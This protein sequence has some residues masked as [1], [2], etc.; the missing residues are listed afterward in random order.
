[1]RDRAVIRKF[2]VV[3]TLGTLLATPSLA[4]AAEE[5]GVFTLGEIEV[6]AKAEAEKNT[7]VEKLYSDEIRLFEKV[8]VADAANLLPGVT[9][10]FTGARNEQT[11]YVRGLDI[12]HVPLFIDGIPVY[13]PYDGYPDLARFTT[14]DLSTLVVSKGF[15]S[16]LYGPNTMGGAINMVSRRPEKTF[17][18]DLGAGIAS[19]ETYS[20][21]INLGTNQGKWYLQGGA[22]YLDSDYFPLSD[23]FTASKNENGGHRDNSYKTDYKFNLKAGFTPNAIDEYAISFIDQNGEK[24]TPVYTGSDRSVTARYWRWPYWDKQSYYFTSKTGIGQSSYVKT[25]AYHDTFKN[26]L[27]S[28]D[29]ATYTKISKKYAFRSWYDD[30]TDGGSLELGSSLLADHTIKLAMHYKRD[31]HR[32]QNEGAPELT[33][34]DQMFSIGL[35]DTWAFMPKFYTIAGIGYDSLDTIE[36]ENLNAKGLIEDFPTEATSGLTPQFGLFFTPG[37]NDTVHISVARKTRL[38]SIKDK[39]SYRLGTAIPNPELDP[40]VSLNYELGYENKDIAGVMVKGTLFYNDVN[41]YIQSAKVANPTSPGKTIDQNQN[42]AEVAFTG[43]ELEASV[44]PLTSLE[45]GGSY[46]L[47]SIDNKTDNSEIVNVPKHKTIAY[48]RYTLLERLTA[49]FDGEYDSKRYSSSNGVQVADD[50]LIFNTK[51]GYAMKNGISLE[52]GAKNLFD[53][54]YEIQEGYPEAGRTFYANLRYT[55]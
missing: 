17:E 46:T 7:T 12:K 26:S 29:D 52:A 54:N 32:E 19:G 49:Q 27:F 18:G 45:V 3:G 55:F 15:T 33:F 22:S 5:Q 14:Y 40:E 36:A 43:I 34:K 38:P 51:L 35:E 6:T 30:Y 4:Q 47:T 10:S 23:D 25:R 1:M 2:M 50:Y 42:I 13:V 28:Y 8:T 53:E 48:V 9:A 31:V 21:Y 37:K 11:L 20:G 16:V 41:D 24:G 39:Y 44:T